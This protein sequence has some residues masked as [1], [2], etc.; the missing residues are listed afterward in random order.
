[1]DP[2]LLFKASDEPPRV[3]NEMEQNLFVESYW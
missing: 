1:M 2:D 3:Q